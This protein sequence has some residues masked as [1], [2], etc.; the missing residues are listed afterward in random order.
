M[1]LFEVKESDGGLMFMIVGIT[2]VLIVLIAL[3]VTGIVVVIKKNYELKQWA[4]QNA[5]EIDVES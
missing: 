3:L 4:K 2:G 1:V 5:T